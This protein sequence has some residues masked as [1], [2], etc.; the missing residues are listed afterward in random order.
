MV[1]E[2]FLVTAMLTLAF[3][4]KSCRMLNINQHFSKLQ[5]PSSGWMCN[6]VVLEALNRAG[7]MWQV[8]SDGADWQSGLLSYVRRACVWGKEMM[9][10]FFYEYVVRKGGD[11][12]FF[13]HMIYSHWIAAHSSASTVS[14]IK[15]ILPPTVCPYKAS[16]THYTTHS[17]WRWMATV[18]VKMLVNIQHLTWLTPESQS[19]TLNSSRENLRTRIM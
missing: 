11:L 1:F 14:T 15:S 10:K 17:L 18:F 8:R 19:Y 2:F 16:R 9:E 5:L 6:G 3:T 7:S 12:L 4:C 13:K